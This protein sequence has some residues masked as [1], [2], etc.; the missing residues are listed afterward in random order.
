VYLPHGGSVTIQLQPGRYRA[1]WF[2]AISGQ[3]IDLPPVAGPEWKS[4]EAPDQNDWA[5]LLRAM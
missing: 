1:S 4:P 5:L 3:V 2:S